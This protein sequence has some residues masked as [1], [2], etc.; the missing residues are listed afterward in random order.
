MG[1]GLRKSTKFDKSCHTDSQHSFWTLGPNWPKG[2]EIDILEGVNEYTNNGM[3]LHTGPGCSIGSDNTQF[4]GNATTT[5]CDVAAIGQSKNVGCSIAHPSKQSYGAG[6]NQIGGGVYATAWNAEAISVYFFPRD[7]IPADVLGDTPDPET[8]GKPAAKFEG[9]CDIEKMFSAQKIIID[10]TFCGQWAGAIWEDGSC[11]S[12]AKTCEEYVRD[13]PDAFTE[14]YWEINALKVYQDDGKPPVAPSPPAT[15]SK[16]SIAVPVPVP[17][18]VPINGTY[19]TIV[20]SVSSQIVPGI[21]SSQL[22][23]SIPSKP[24]I[25]PPV[26][27]LP[28]RNSSLPSSRTR[29]PRPSRPINSQN[30][31]APS[32]GPGGMPGFAFPVG[33]DSGSDDAPAPPAQQN[34]TAVAPVATPTSLINIAPSSQANVVVPSDA[35]PAIPVVPGDQNDKPV[36]TVYQTVY[37]TKTAGVDGVATPAAAAGRMARH[38]REH[39]KRHGGRF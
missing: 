34:S 26:V 8:W 14:A 1:H 9:A 18:S 15:P 23:P 30:F 3:T 39:R 32:I 27:P 4:S 20:P 6:L 19:P 25:T 22:A 16:S 37:V 29:R 11:A 36:R 35:P 13:N 2:G 38:V 28:S 12:K 5:N 31:A 17:S 21:P 7:S 33:G 10:T 24:T